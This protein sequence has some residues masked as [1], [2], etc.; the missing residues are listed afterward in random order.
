MIF[1]INVYK[2][3]YHFLLVQM[4]NR[5]VKRPIWRVHMVNTWSVIFQTIDI[6]VGHNKEYCVLQSSKFGTHK[7]SVDLYVHST[8]LYLSVRT[9][10]VFGTG[11]CRHI[12]RRRDAFSLRVAVIA[13]FSSTP[14]LRQ[15]RNNMQG[16]K[17]L[18]EKKAP[19][20]CIQTFSYL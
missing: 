4:H 10:I 6:E 20:K 12:H 13:F 18:E 2:N 14:I 7:S 19:Y 9:R 16:K 17:W 3:L 11:A 8:I 15:W 5:Y 1:S